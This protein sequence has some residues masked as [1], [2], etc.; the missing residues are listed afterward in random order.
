MA[1][2]S[3]VEEVARKIKEVPGVSGLSL[4]QE[5]E[6]FECTCSNDLDIRDLLS[7]LIKEGKVPEDFK[8]NGYTEII[9][10]F[11]NCQKGIW[12]KIKIFHQGNNFTF[13]A[14]SRLLAI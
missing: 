5:D 11:L 14:V 8:M 7:P 3:I 6:S 4:N 10:P 12:Q 1:E 13:R 9:L 2:I